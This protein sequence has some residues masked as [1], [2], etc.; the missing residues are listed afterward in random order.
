MGDARSNTPRTWNDEKDLADLA[1]ERGPFVTVHLATPAAQENAA[2]ES[3]LRWRS[4]RGQLEATGV[5]ETVLDELEAHVGDAHL[6]GEG[7]YVVATEAGVRHVSHW[8]Q[9]PAIEFAT[10]QNLP[11]LAPLI[12]L[13]QH[14]VPHVCATLDRTGAVIN[15]YRHEGN[16]MQRVTKG[17]P[18]DP[19]RKVNAGGWSQKRYELRAEDTWEH[20]AKDAAAEIEEMAGRV[21]ARCIFMAGDVRAVQ[22]AQNALSHQ[23]RQLVEEVQ[24]SKANDGSPLID[25]VAVRAMLEGMVDSDTQ[26]LLSK[27]AEER[28]QDDR[29][30]TGPHDVL[31]ALAAGRVEV[32]LVSTTHDIVD[33]WFGEEP[34]QVAMSD[35]RVRAIGARSPMTGR[36]VDVAISSAL[37]T[38]AGV[39]VIDD[40]TRIP[41]GIAALL[42]W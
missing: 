2:Q 18:T 14:N 13:R 19:I 40:M 41:S 9:S 36:L 4:M 33:A 42:R 10:R 15:G 12:A 28:G 34:T 3:L 24:G 1:G 26:A 29:A 11:V 22:L 31:G 20:N 23:A 16:A 5:T 35:D 21:S 6:E 38:S 25:E 7:L 32:L 17:D 8:Q 37:R 27:L 30:V 39:R